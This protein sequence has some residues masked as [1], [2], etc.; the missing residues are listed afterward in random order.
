MLFT[1]GQEGLRYFKHT[2]RADQLR[3]SGKMMVKKIIPFRAKKCLIRH[4]NNK[5]YALY[6][7]SRRP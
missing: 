3:K 5:V 2:W 6:T 7:W 4:D 1:R